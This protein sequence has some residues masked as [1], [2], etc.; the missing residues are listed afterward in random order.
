MT[1]GTRRVGVHAGAYSV[2]EV[3][4]L[5]GVTIRTLHHYGEIGLLTPSG[6]ASAGYRQYAAADLDR[7][8]QILFYRELGFPLDQIADLLDDP[9]ANPVDHLRRQHELLTARLRR[10]QTMVAAVE[11]ELEATMSGINLTSEEK[12][13]V[14]GASYNEEWEAEAEER[15]GGTEDW[16]QSQAEAAKRTKEDWATFRADMEATHGRLVAGFTSGLASDSPEAMDLAENHLRWVS[17]SWDC[18]PRLHRNLVDMYLADE[19][20]ANTYEDMAPG[21][22]Q[23][24]RD[25]AHANADRIEGTA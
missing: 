18:T 15:W 11:K 12:L 1:A 25:A 7:L 3:A 20:F 14:F 22:T 9:S 13:E 4:R 24:L 2:G 10:V 16:E 17:L 6:R 5:A 19:R 21:L 23:W 8:G